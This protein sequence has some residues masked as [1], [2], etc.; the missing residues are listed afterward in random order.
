[1]PPPRETLTHVVWG[2]LNTKTY[3][4]VVLL[5]MAGAGVRVPLLVWLLDAKLQLTNRVSTLL[6]DKTM[7]WLEL[8][9][10]QHRIAHLPRSVHIACN[11][12]MHPLRYLELIQ[13]TVTNGLNTHLQGYDWS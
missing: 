10:T 5:H 2:F 13:L 7:H 8:F 1:M 3:T 12:C 9:Y 4:L 11:A 6:S